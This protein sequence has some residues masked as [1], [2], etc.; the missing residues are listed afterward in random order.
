[1]PHV[2]KLTE[3]NWLKHLPPSRTHTHLNSQASQNWWAV[4]ALGKKL[5]PCQNLSHIICIHSAYYWSLKSQDKLHFQEA[6][7]PKEGWRTDLPPFPDII[8]FP[9]PWPTSPQSLETHSPVW[10]NTGLIWTKLMET[11]VLWWDPGLQFLSSLLW[12]GYLYW[13]RPVDSNHHP[14]FFFD[15]NRIQFYSGDTTFSR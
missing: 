11:E 12:I 1:M 9:G 7:N 13:L 5:L 4:L 10:N 14:P 15:N 6:Q 8:P 3:V 2:C